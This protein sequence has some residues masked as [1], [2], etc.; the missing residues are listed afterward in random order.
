MKERKWQKDRKDQN[1]R[2]LFM[3][4]IVGEEEKVVE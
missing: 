2:A 1:K 3:F 4:Q